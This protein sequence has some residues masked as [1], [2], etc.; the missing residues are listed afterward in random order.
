MP[1]IP[2]MIRGGVERIDAQ[3]RE[4]V[5]TNGHDRAV[6]TWKEGTHACCLKP[7]DTVKA[8]YRKAPGSY[9]ISDLRVPSF[10]CCN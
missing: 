7:G 8:Y 5:V 3:Q 4:L 9:V 1:P 2:H 10:N 6:L